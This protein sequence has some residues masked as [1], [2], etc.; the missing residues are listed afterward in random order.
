M[1]TESIK[2]KDEQRDFDRNLVTYISY[3]I[4]VNSVALSEL[5]TKAISILAD[6]S[7]DCN[8]RSHSQWTA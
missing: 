4:C 5:N 7:Q 2:M 3:I 1:Y 6:Q 8:L